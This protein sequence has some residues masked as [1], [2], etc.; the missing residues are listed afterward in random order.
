MVQ[1][2][3]KWFFVTIV[4]QI[5]VSLRIHALIIND[6]KIFLLFWHGFVFFNQ[7]QKKIPYESGVFSFFAK[8]Q[9]HANI[10]FPLKNKPRQS[11]L[12]CVAFS[13]TST[14]HFPWVHAPL[15]PPFP[16]FPSSSSNCL[17]S[18][19]GICFADFGRYGGHLRI[20]HGARFCRHYIGRWSA[21]AGGDL[22][23]S[24]RRNDQRLF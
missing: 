19:F 12:L 17:L 3:F 4:W 11:T 7:A 5:K 21:G 16:I 18:P 14:T 23:R 1:F 15:F 13:P 10:F 9:F 22:C 6:L 20:Q 24:G 2:F 8:W